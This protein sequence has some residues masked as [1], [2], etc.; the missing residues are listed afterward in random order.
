MKTQ[1]CLLLLLVI[2]LSGAVYAD[3]AIEQDVSS[4]LEGMDT[5]AIDG[6]GNT[7]GKLR[8]GNASNPGMIHFDFAYGAESGMYGP[9][10]FILTKRD[11][12]RLERKI[13]KDEK[14][15]ASSG[16][17]SL[18]VLVRLEMNRQLLSKLKTSPRFSSGRG[19]KVYFDVA[20]LFEK[21]NS[22]ADFNRTL[23]AAA[24][25][26]MGDDSLARAAQSGDYSGISGGAITSAVGSSV[27]NSVQSSVRSSVQQSVQSTV[28][29]TAASVSGGGSGSTSNAQNGN[30][31]N[32]G[33]GAI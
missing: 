27:R 26:T 30:G 6:D 7:A 15:L 20:E 10:Q 32:G 14:K 25:R 22:D 8:Q 4:L 17:M 5:S 18:K 9:I 33:G 23:V 28:S 29:Q 3:D 16:N 2:I 1:K 11:V 12:R 31:G 21:A 24:A 13:A 19:C